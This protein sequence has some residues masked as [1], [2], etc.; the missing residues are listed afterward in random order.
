MHFQHK[1]WLHYWCSA[2][3]RVVQNILQYS[4]P[5]SCTWIFL[6]RFQAKNEQEMYPGLLLFFPAQ[7]HVEK[8][9]SI[10]PGNRGSVTETCRKNLFCSIRSEVGRRMWREGNAVAHTEWKSALT[11][12]A[13]LL[14]LTEKWI[15]MK[16]ALV[17]IICPHPQREW[18]WKPLFV[19]SVCVNNITNSRSVELSRA[20]VPF[21]WSLGFASNLLF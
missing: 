1:N 10:S 16:Y 3:G 6:G 2:Q 13:T 8:E 14:L 5:K 19:P 12:I 17:A 7:M 20:A 11:V 4:V 15:K 18:K 9:M 21:V